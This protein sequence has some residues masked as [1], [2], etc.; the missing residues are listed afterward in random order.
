M[1]AIKDEYVTTAEAANILGINRVTLH[2]WAKQGTLRAYSLGPRRVLF[3]RSD[4]SE[5]L[6]PVP[7]AEVATGMKQR[8]GRVVEPLSDGQVE[9]GLVA[10]R[11]GRE[12][13]ERIAKRRGGKPWTPSWE[14][15]NEARDE[16]ATHQG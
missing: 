3:K 13:G 16:R 2:R 14:L 8:L 9:Q 4:L 10:M 5:L 12:L 11:A 15:I 6:K 1:Q 7:V